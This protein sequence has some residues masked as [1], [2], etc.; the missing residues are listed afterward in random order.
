MSSIEYLETQVMT[1]TPH[2]LH[3]MVVDGALR[4][5]R[6]GKLSLEENDYEMAHM[7]LAQSRDF[8]NELLG[9]MDEKKSP[10]L[11]DQ[12][13]G[14]FVFIFKSLAA[15]DLEKKPEFA[16]DAISI[17][18][19]HRETWVELGEKLPNAKPNTSDSE[20]ATDENGNIIRKDEG[21]SWTM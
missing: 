9:G 6:Q 7:A 12:M 17:L 4:F 8:M 19:K 21:H 3:L 14:L 5:A 1:A 15:A 16:Q 13:K 11:V 10:E 18:E 20:M 2:Q